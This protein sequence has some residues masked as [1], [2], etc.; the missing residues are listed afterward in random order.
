MAT[1]KMTELTKALED[2]GLKAVF[3]MSGGNTG[4]IYIGEADA[5]GYYEFAVGPS[6]YYLDEAV[7]GDFCWGV[8]GDS[9]ETY[10]FG[11]ESDFTIENVANLIAKDY[12][13][14]TMFCCGFCGLSRRGY[15]GEVV[16]NQG[17]IEFTCNICKSLA[18]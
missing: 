7:M 4:T 2:R 3:T 17:F 10:F 9:K 8:D 16:N 15:L 18:S 13:V 6:N 12:F 5:E 11:N 14:Q 1:I